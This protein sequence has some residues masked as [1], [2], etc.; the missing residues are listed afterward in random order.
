MSDRLVDL[1][2]SIER[3]LVAL[4]TL[5]RGT[6]NRINI[7]RASDQIRFVVRIGMAELGLGVKRMGKIIA[8]EKRKTNPFKCSVSITEDS[9]IPSHRHEGIR[10]DNIGKIPQKRWSEPIVIWTKRPFGVM[11]KRNGKKLE[12]CEG[13]KKSGQRNSIYFA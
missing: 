13:E 2:E 12:I 3:I 5:G 6:I 8:Y 10:L 11:V 7:V 1:K 4:F 9:Q